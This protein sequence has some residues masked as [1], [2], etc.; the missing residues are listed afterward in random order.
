MPPPT[1]AKS[2]CRLAPTAKVS[3][4][5]VSV[6]RPSGVLAASVR[7]QSPANHSEM[8]RS[9]NPVTQ[10]PMTAP[11][12]NAT[13]SPPSRLVFAA[14]QVRADALVAVFIPRNPHSPESSAATPTPT[15]VSGCCSPRNASTASTITSAATARYTTFACFPRYAYAPRRTASATRT[16]AGSPSEVSMN[17]L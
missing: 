11:A 3:V 15:G 6:T 4:S 10:R 16:I 9:A 14:W 8:S 2:A 7:N 1:R 5:V 17:P 13:R 12:R